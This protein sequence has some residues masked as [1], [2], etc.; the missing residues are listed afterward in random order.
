MKY[1]SPRMANQGVHELTSNKGIWDKNKLC[2]VL[3]TASL[4][5]CIKGVMTSSFLM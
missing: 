5:G 4:H 1:A 3:L 2:N